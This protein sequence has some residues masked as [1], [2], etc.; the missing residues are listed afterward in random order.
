MPEPLIFDHTNPAYRIRWNRS[1]VNRWNGA[2]YYSREIVRNIIPNVR[3]DR[4]WVTVNRYG[5][6]A[7]HSIVFIHN[8]LNPER[9]EWLSSYSDL[10]L[11]CGVPSTCR[12]VEHLGKAVYLPLSV[13]VA[14]VQQFQTRKYLNRAF[15]GRPSKA[16]G[17]D[18]PHYTRIIG[19]M[20]RKQVLEAMAPYKSVYAVGRCAIEARILGCKVLPY[21]ERFPNPDVWAVV[22][23]KV[24]ARKLQGILAMV[25][26]R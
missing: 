12:K 14:Y 5:Q 1:G 13:D 15:V 20:R 10:I 26:G 11:V 2:Y 22:D 21:D 17:H 7:D 24:A 19:G 16:K 6:C 8:N 23:N 25:D 3:T 18:F 4:N 9:Y